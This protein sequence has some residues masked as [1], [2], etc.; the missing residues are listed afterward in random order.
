MEKMQNVKTKIAFT[1]KFQF[2]ILYYLLQMEFTKAK[3]P[4][5]GEKKNE[6]KVKKNVN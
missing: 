4:T 6:I 3:S 5:Y 2:Y 1:P